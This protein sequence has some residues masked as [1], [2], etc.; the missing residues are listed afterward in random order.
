MGYAERDVIIRVLC[1]TLPA[2]TSA[3]ARN[4]EMKRPRRISRTS[5]WN[6]IGVEDVV[7]FDLTLHIDQGRD[8][9]IGDPFLI[10]VLTVEH[11][12]GGKARRMSGC[13]LANRADSARPEFRYDSPQGSHEFGDCGRLCVFRVICHIN[14]PAAEYLYG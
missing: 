13:V 2:V 10:F 11:D 7:P 4:M 3:T 5:C 14:L 1:Q 6:P 12:V 8:D 9:V